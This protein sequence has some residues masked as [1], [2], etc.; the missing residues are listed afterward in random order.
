LSAGEWPLCV[1]R[2]LSPARSRT[3]NLL[4]ARLLPTLAQAQWVGDR[5]DLDGT[6]L[7]AA[8][9]DVIVSFYRETDGVTVASFDTVTPSV[10]QHHSEVPAA[11]AALP[12]GTY[13]VV[14]RVN[15]Q[16]ARSS[17]RLVVS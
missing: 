9:D 3:S 16:Q 17:P 6:L 10:D 4:L 2:R 11:R 1:R 7:G 8:H 14:L 15:N 12:P 5:L 13:R